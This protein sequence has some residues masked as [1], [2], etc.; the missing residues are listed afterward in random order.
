MNIADPIALLFLVL[1]PV[2]LWVYWRGLKTRR[3]GLRFSDLSVIQTIRSAPM[4]RFRHVPLLIRS[5]VIGLIVF[6]LARPQAGV[7]GEEVTTE[8]IDIVLA[9]DISGSMRAEDFKPNNRLYVAKQ[10]L[11]EFVKRRKSDRIGMVVFAGRSFT[12]CPL[13]LDYNVLLGLIEQIQIGMVEDGTAIGMGIAN[14]V[15][16]L[17]KSNAKSR[18]II[19]LTDG[20]NNTGAIDPL[21]AAQ[22]AKALGV[23]IYTIGVGKEGG[24]PIPVDDPLFGKTYARNRDGSLVLTEIDEE[25]LKTIAKSTDG[26]YFR[27]ADAQA[28]AD[29]YGRIDAMERTEIKTVEYT[30]YRELFAY[31]LLPALVF[32]VAETAL[33]HTRLRRLP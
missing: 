12:Q 15:N 2:L 24:A 33:A 16:R 27:A 30:R 19:L 20:V 18:V 22:A 4:L 25:L 32:A 28:L 29:I 21:T 5:L 17:R 26:A 9:L 31:L 8:G 14:S 13:T 10:V 11:S 1:I 6:A 23:K 3:G 7:H